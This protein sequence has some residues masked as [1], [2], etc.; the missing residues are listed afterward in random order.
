MYLR[1]FETLLEYDLH[2]VLGYS[3][4][5]LR[6]AP[7][8]KRGKRWALNKKK[9]FL[10]AN[11]WKCFDPFMAYVKWN[12]DFIQ[13]LLTNIPGDLAGAI[14][15]EH[16]LPHI[17]VG[18]TG[19]LSSFGPKWIL[20]CMLSAKGVVA[21]GLR[22]RLDVVRTLR[23]YSPDQYSLLEE[24]PEQCTGGPCTVVSGGSINPNGR[25]DYLAYFDKLFSG[26]VMD[27]SFEGITVMTPGGLALVSPLRLMPCNSLIGPCG[28]IPQSLVYATNQLLTIVRHLCVHNT[29]GS[30]VS[31][32]TLLR[33]ALG[34]Q[35]P[36]VLEAG[37]YKS[38]DNEHWS[39]VAQVVLQTATLNIGCVC[40]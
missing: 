15:K 5:Y 32:E 7:L 24:Y 40:K 20:D 26:T 30:L 13:I 23:A 31:L 14:A 12:E 22:Q 4:D 34:I 29:R 19:E 8:I 2:L 39:C 36:V 25:A 35:G 6:V 10:I 17:P 18:P 27:S 33:I 37:H 16:Q 28:V 9:A 21:N 3:G 11:K 38:S 1:E